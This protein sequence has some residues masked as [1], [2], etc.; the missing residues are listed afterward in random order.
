MYFHF[1]QIIEFLCYLNVSHL[2]KITLRNGAYK[3]V[4]R[5]QTLRTFL[6]KFETFYQINR[7]LVHYQTLNSENNSL[8]FE[9][10]FLFFSFD[11][12][13]LRRREERDS[14]PPFLCSAPC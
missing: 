1:S 11:R 5:F 13:E 4:S 9:V 7:T 12:G 14:K 2:N 3:S 8:I 6:V 10:L